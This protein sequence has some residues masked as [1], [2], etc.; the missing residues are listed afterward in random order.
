MLE[1]GVECPDIVALIVYDTN[2]VHFLSMADEKLVWNINKKEIYDKANKKKVK[3][4]FYRTELQFFYKNYM[5]SVDVA[6]Q[7]QNSSNFQYWMRNRKWWWALFMCGF[8]VM[9]VK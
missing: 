2:P 9:L 4:K 5:N 7:L 3:L 6:N 1:G 8:G